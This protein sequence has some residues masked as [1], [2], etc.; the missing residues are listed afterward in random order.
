MSDEKCE[1]LKQ[2]HKNAKKPLYFQAKIKP[3]STANKIQEITENPQ[4]GLIAKIDIKA[5]PENNKA[6][7]ELIRFLAHTLCLPPNEIRLISGQS[8]RTK[9]IRINL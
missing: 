5:K 7:L 8:S 2:I 3:N 6:N 1:L 9:L 4:I